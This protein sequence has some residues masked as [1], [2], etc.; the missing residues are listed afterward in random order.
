VPP[1]P[2]PQPQPQGLTVS[3]LLL[4]AKRLQIDAARRLAQRAELV[5]RI[6]QLIHELQKERGASSVYL[7]SAGQRFAQ[8]REQAMQEA[9]VAELLLREGFSQQ[10]APQQGASARMLDLMAWALLGLEGLEELR[11]RIQARQIHSHEAVT[12]YSRLIGGLLE[13]IVEVADAALLPAISRLLVALLHL[14][15]G[16]ELAGQERAVGAELFAS[17]R[18]DEGWQQ[19]LQHLIDAQERSLQVFEQFAQGELLE[20]WEALQQASELIRLERLRR[21]L[22]SARAASSL[23]SRQSD[24]WFDTCSQRI[25]ALRGLQEALVLQLRLECE[26]QVQQAERELQ[27]SEGLL[28]RLRQGPPRHGDA[29]A[30][31]FDPQLPAQ[32]V[33]TLT[34]EPASAGLAAAP[35]GAMDPATSPEPG[36]GTGAGAGDTALLELLQQQSARL[37]EVEAELEATRRTLSER[38][39]IDRAKA[40][41]M[42]RMGMSEE[43]AFRALQKTSMDQNRRLVEVAQATLALPDFAFAP[44]A[45]TG[46][47]GDSS[48]RPR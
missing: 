44:L 13:L 20:R 27:D 11:Q 28:Q 41:L 26:A 31:F 43:Q 42:S 34:R 36:T 47:D 37:A 1:P 45:G 30:R 7:A 5:G 35:P 33:P 22:C 39:V 40:L 4:S 15:Q 16:S 6:G 17:G 2:Q 10:L 21:L 32:P 24:A 29:V 3:T 46:V 38:K 9:R 18:C 23:D 8:V 12:A 14:V 19:Q 48:R 25:G